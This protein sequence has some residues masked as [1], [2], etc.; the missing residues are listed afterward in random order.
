M[1]QLLGSKGLLGYVDGKVTAPP[2]PKPEDP[3]PDT[4]PIYSSTPN[5]D[6]WNFQDQLSRGHITLNCTDVAGD[7][8][9]NLLAV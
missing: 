3:T 8:P 2:K 7:V 6:E 1:Y 9:H 4:T 5:Y